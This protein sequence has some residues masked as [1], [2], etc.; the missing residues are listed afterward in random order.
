MKNDVYLVY[1]GLDGDSGRLYSIH[2]SH[3][4]AVDFIKSIKPFLCLEDTHR[5]LFSGFNG[6]RTEWA[7]I[8]LWEIM[9]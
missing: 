1:V 8:D 5:D 2:S 7:R 9:G 6:K 4:K 3:K